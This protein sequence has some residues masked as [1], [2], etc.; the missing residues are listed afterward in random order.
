MQSDRVGYLESSCRG[1]LHSK[2]VESTEL[3]GAL[4]L[5][6]PAGQATLDA[7]C[8]ALDASEVPWLMA[9]QDELGC[10]ILP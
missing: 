4:V 7:Q 3:V 2:A 5:G 8:A 9:R 6:L 1:E 10:Q